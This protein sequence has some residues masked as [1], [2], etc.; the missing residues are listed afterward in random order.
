MF[1]D[2]YQINTENQT[3]NA[4]FNS[5][6]SRLLKGPPTLSRAE[7]DSISGI[8]CKVLNN[9]KV[10]DINDTIMFTISINV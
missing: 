9:T 8:W 1:G 6:Q 2:L 5:R 4:K 10:V 7:P 3:N